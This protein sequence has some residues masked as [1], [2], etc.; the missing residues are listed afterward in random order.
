MR[1]CVGVYVRVGAR[2]REPVLHVEQ[3][4]LVLRYLAHELITLRFERRLLDA[5]GKR[6]ELLLETL[7]RD[8]E[9]DHVHA[10]EHVRAELRLRFRCCDDH[11]KILRVFVFMPCNADQRAV[12]RVLVCLLEE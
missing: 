12:R 10:N 2:V 5:D 3:V 6:H 8:G 11:R 1:T 4:D 9:V 7:S